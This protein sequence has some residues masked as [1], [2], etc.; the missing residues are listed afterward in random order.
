[1]DYIKPENDIVN[2]YSQAWHIHPELTFEI[3]EGSKN[4]KTTSGTTANLVVAPVEDSHSLEVQEMPG[5]YSFTA[6]SAALAHNPYVSYVKNQTGVTT[7][8]TVLYPMRAGE[9]K[10]VETQKLSLAL[11]DEAADAFEAVIRDNNAGSSQN[12]AYYTLFDETQKSQQQFGSYSTDGIL[13]FVEKTGTNYTHAIL[14]SGTNLSTAQGTPIISSGSEIE[15]MSVTWSG[16]QMSI[17]S[18]TMDAVDLNSLKILGNANVQQVL[19]NGAAA[20]FYRDGDYICFTDVGG[21]STPTPGAGTGSGNG[22]THATAGGSGT[23][24]SGNG[25]A[26]G[27]TGSGSIGGGTQTENGF[28]DIAGHWAEKYIKSAAAADIVNGDEAG[29]FNPDRNITRAELL[30]MAMRALNMESVAYDGTFSDVQ[31][32][33][34]F[35]GTVAQALALGIIAKDEQFRPRDTVTR[36]EMCK[37]LIG[38][39]QQ[40]QKAEADGGA[41]LNFADTEKIS[42][43]AQPYVAQA[44]QLGYM[45]G[46]ENNKFSPQGSATRAQAVTVI[47]RILS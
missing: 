19:V 39:A 35:A 30:A 47:Q 18:S 9:N 21:G 14:R 41:T 16:N 34:W 28:A 17:N 43:W 31:A 11:P 42:A 45:Q 25:S 32:E 4:V 15:N 20:T 10:S 3:E 37:I 8:N 40:L 5:Y 24:S 36:E 12:L 7:F 29:N 27:G 6:N 38:V 26:G 13:G 33:D 2:K 44:T 22:N 1:T 46:M 23:G